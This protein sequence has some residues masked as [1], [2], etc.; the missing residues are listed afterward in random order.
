MDEKTLEILGYLWIRN[1]LLT[2]T[3][4]DVKNSV[5]DMDHY[6]LY[7]NI[8]EKL[9]DEDYHL[10]YPETQDK[11]IDALQ[12]YRFEADP[13]IIKKVND[14]IDKL[15]IDKTISVAEKENRVADFYANEFVARSM[16]VVPIGCK[17]VID[18]LVKNDIS[19]FIDAYIGKEDAEEADFKF[20]VSDPFSY[21]A[22]LNLIN[23]RFP[24][25]YLI[26]D[27]Q[28][29]TSDEENILVGEFTANVLKKLVK[30]NYYRRSIRKY[31][32]RTIKD[33]EY[34]VNVES[35]PKVLE[36]TNN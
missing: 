15:N 33:I 32:K 12:T 17:L 35:K 14:I 4:E 31:F 25:F 28:A 22:M 24:Y 36:K 20:T 6:K 19:F 5:K 8:I 11:I 7:V 27:A 18:A 16:P 29:Q 23:A 9:L 21:L 30:E 13:D 34:T 1:K 10:A 3:K 2:N 26:D